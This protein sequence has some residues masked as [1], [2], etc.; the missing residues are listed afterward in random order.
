L[1]LVSVLHRGQAA[2]GRGWRAFREDL[3]GLALGFGLVAALVTATAWLL[4]M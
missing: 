3:L 1:L 2:A 4:A